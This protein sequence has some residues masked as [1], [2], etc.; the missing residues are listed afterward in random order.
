[1]PLP[2]QTFRLILKG[3]FRLCYKNC[4][5]LGCMQEIACKNRPTFYTTHP[6]PSNF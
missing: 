6:T 1:M 3:A 2:T 4:S 5:N